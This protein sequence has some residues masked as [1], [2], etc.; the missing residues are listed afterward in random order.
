MSRQSS[1]VNFTHKPNRFTCIFIPHKN[2][3]ATH[4]AKLFQEGLDTLYC[5]FSHD[6]TKFQTTTIDPVYILVKGSI[7]VAEN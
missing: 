3:C 7:R 5:R 4:L 1:G 2:I 6:V